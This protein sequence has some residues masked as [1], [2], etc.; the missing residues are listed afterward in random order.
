MQQQVAT[1]PIE[2][3][4]EAFYV[5]LTAWGTIAL[6]FATIFMIAWQI[7]SAKST[8]RVQWS[9]TL[10]DRYES[11]EG[12]AMR[13]RL[14]ELLIQGVDIPPSA[15][16]QV[17][18]MLEAVADLLNRGWLDKVTIENAFSIAIRYWW[19][20]LEMRIAKMRSDYHDT[21]FYDQ[22]EQLAKAYDA[23]ERRRG[24]PPLTDD[25]VLI[26]LKSEAL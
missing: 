6:V 25:E 14:A 18:D 7:R 21:T 19:H 23:V 5:A 4:S 13:K 24:M 10:M 1:C 3:H 15:I 20:A 22:F 9:M 8:S 11:R 17:I 16:E 12:R 26:F 2:A